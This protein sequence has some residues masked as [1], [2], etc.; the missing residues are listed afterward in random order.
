[1]RSNSRD[2]RLTLEMSQLITRA[3]TM[4]LATAIPIYLDDSELIR[5][6]TIILNDLNKTLPPEV[7]LL[8]Q[9]VG[10]YYDLPLDWFKEPMHE[11]DFTK[12][13]LSCTQVVQDFD[14]YFKCLCEIHK[15]RRKY[16]RIL[17]AQPLPTM[18]QISPRTLLEFGIIASP[19]LASWMVCK[20]W[21]YDIDNRAAQE[22][23]YLFEPI[24]ASA[25]GGVS[26]SARNSPIRRRS[27]PK[28]GRQVDCIVDKTAYE[29]KLRVTI[30]A[31]G[32]G[33]FAQELDFAE[34]CRNSG[35]S[36]VLLVLD[37]TPSARLEEL[38]KEYER[39][40]GQTYIGDKAWQHIEEQAGATMGT[41]VEKYVRR[42]IA[43]IDTYASNLLNLSISKLSSESAFAVELSNEQES[44]SWRINRKED[45][46]LADE[47]TSL[48]DEY[49]MDCPT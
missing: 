37:P 43:E 33:R 29:F 21:F 17:S 44:F 11:A 24:L 45:Q 38:S 13:Y 8:P 48:E 41:F 26:C 36:P 25:L 20:K 39:V 40:E 27:D 31:S 4:G 23:G 28:K 9:K 46:T 12:I 19:A 34:D 7:Y 32:Q 6:V 22:T 16:E 10:N 30:A 35:F 18:L 5:L 14:T 3:R 2:K 15:R 42:P 47:T 49:F 1:M